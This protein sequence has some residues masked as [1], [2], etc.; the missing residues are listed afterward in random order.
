VFGFLVCSYTYQNCVDDKCVSWYMI[1]AYKYMSWFLCN[2]AFLQDKW[3]NLCLI[4]TGRGCREKVAVA[5]KKSRQIPKLD[6]NQRALSNVEDFS[7]EIVDA[8][9]LATS[10]EFLQTTTPKRLEA[11]L[12]FQLH[13]ES[14]D[15]FYLYNTNISR[16]S[17]FTPYWYI[18]TVFDVSSVQHLYMSV[19]IRLFK[20]L[21]LIGRFLFV[22]MHM[23]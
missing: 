14:Y 10:T 7:D 16:A 19:F 8:K 21:L 20:K 18:S 6:N 3:R 11:K 23:M 1:V 12:V 5:L 17:L 13:C 2:S 9:P 22:S 4:P 15:C